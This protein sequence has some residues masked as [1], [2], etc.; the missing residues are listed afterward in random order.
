MHDNSGINAHVN[1]SLTKESNKNK[2]LVCSN[3]SWTFVCAT[4][5]TAIEAT[6]MIFL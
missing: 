3:N 1:I 5:H 6:L 4:N 2:L